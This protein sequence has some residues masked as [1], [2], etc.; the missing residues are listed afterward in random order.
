MRKLI[1]FTFLIL[2]SLISF[3]DGGDYFRLKLQVKQIDNSVATGYI[4]FGTHK[5]F[6][7]SEKES[8]K[9][10][11]KRELRFPL[12]VY[13]EIKTIN[14]NPNFQLD[15]AETDNFIE[16]EL[17][18]VLEIKLIEKLKYPAGQRL[19]YLTGKEYNLIKEEPKHKTY[20][21]NEKL[22]PYCSYKLLSW[23]EISEFENIKNEIDEKLKEFA[24]SDNFKEARN[25]MKNIKLELVEKGILI[26][27]S[28]SMP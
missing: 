16:L 25:Y 14:I 15:F 12:K 26:F 23:T 3:A 20:I 17:S 18:E 13:K 11:A 28:C 22:I 4:Y 2:T 7:D 6:F 8:F 21:A 27:Q 9:E 5:P 24:E 1:L 10:Y 19:V